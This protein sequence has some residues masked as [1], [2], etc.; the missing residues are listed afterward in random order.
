MPN[1]NLIPHF[2]IPYLNISHLLYKKAK[3]FLKS[4]IINIKLNKNI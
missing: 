3:L 2:F 1:Q 4:I